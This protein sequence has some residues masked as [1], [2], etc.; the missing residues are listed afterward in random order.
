MMVAWLIV[1]VTVALAAAIGILRAGA[2]SFRVLGG[3][4]ALLL[5]AAWLCY[6]I[7][8]GKTGGYLAGIIGALLSL[9]LLIAA[10]GLAAG[11]LLRWVHDRLRPPPVLRAPF[12]QPWDI[13]GLG[14]FAALAVVLSALE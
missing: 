12:S 6:L 7:G 11:A 10:G 8:D 1:L 9:L 3:E 13:V 4:L 5:G 14:C 2:R